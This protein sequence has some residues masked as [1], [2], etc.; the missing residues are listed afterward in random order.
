MESLRSADDQRGWQ[1]TVQPLLDHGLL[2]VVDGPSVLHATAEGL[3]ELVPTP[4]HTPG[5]QSVTIVSAGRRAVVTG[6]VF[7]HA[8]QVANPKVA[9]TYEE[10]PDQAAAT[11]RDLLASARRTGTTLANPHL[12]VPFLRL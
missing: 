2:D 10:C 1:R 9:Y 6:D 5:H 4:G 12:M 3:V 11:R 7:V 8:V